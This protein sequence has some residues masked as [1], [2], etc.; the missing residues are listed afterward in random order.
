MCADPRATYAVGA[1]ALEP[2]SYAGRHW[3]IAFGAPAG[4]EARGG[5]SALGAGA[6]RGASKGVR[7]IGP[8]VPF[9]SE[10]RAALLLD[11]RYSGYSAEE[12]GQGVVAVGG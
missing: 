3:R 1:G 12:A 6:A 11:G 5:G 4:A 9:L 10:G 2:G 7:G 8:R